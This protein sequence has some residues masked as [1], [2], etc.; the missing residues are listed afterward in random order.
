MRDNH[1]PRGLAFMD[2]WTAGRAEVGYRTSAGEVREV[3]QV[4]GIDYLSRWRK[5]RFSVL[6]SG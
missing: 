4:G 5:T 3:T 1:P 2:G 6:H